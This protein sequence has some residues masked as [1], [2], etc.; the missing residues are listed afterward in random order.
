[1]CHEGSVTAVLH[2]HY[3]VRTIDRCA[4][5]LATDAIPQPQRQVYRQT[6]DTGTRTDLTFSTHQGHPSLQGH[7]CLCSLLFDLQSDI[8]GFF[9]TDGRRRT[10]THPTGVS[11]N[12][13]FIQR[14]RL[15]LSAQQCCQASLHPHAGLPCPLRPNRMSETRRES[16]VLR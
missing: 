16:T 6:G 5:S 14:R 9:P 4:R 2:D 15:V 12:T 3:L 7:S 13:C 1:M 10:C 11:C 8:P